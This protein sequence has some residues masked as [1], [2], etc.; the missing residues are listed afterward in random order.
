[1]YTKSVYALNK[2][3]LS[4]KHFASDSLRAL[5]FILYPSELSLF[6]CFFSFL[7]IYIGEN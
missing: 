5:M 7:K 4:L 3:I 2:I 6:V 1:M